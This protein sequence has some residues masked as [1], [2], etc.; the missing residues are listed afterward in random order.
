MVGMIAVRCFV[1]L[2]GILVL[3]A[4]ATSAK[5]EP[6][7]DAAIIDVPLGTETKPI[8]FR[9]VVVKLKRGE[10]LGAL[11]MGIFCAPNAN[12]IY[13]QRGATVAGEDFTH[14]FREELEAANYTVV[15]D[16]DA[17][18]EDASTWKAEYLVAGLIKSMQANV[19]FPMAGFGD[20]LTSKGEVYIKVDWQIYS[21]LDRRVVYETSTEGAVKQASASQDGADAAFAE[22][23][24]AATR[25]LLA[26][27]GFH[28]LIA[29]NEQ[30]EAAVQLSETDISITPLPLYT[31]PLT[32]NVTDIR[33]SVATVFAGNGH[34]SGFF[35]MDGYLL[36]NQHVVGTAE[37]VKVK[38][39]TG[40]E[41]VGE[42]IAR[43]A[44]RDVAVVRTE[45]IG[46]AGLPINI[47]EPPIGSKV[48]AIGTPIEEA[49]AST[50]S[51]G[52]L[53]SYRTEDGIPFI[54]SDV[55]ILPGNS[56]GPLLDENG[57]VI[58]L[59]V[60]GLLVGG[61]ASIGLNYFVPIGDA[62]KTLAIKTA[63]AS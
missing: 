16:P 23:F 13:K 40:R 48:Y 9:K 20:F 55:N 26:D 52:I 41:I 2:L 38:L 4:C 7:A 45:P 11:E 44:R 49:K 25:H 8:Q 60:K 17:L 35:V 30:D 28:R 29:L 62:L 18:F 10:P 1:F 37:F 63:E 3:G 59:S 42:V 53:S 15:G 34:G 24:A 12:L 19:C 39:V 21:R 5:I 54:Q 46:L 47:S 27:E 33:Q 36:T 50:V 56:G 32:D 61:V 51:A 22:A 58:G 14:V 31:K 6:T 57:N 43:H